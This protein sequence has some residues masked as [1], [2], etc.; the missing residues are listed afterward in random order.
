MLKNKSELEIAMYLAECIADWVFTARF[1]E[2][3]NDFSLYEDLNCFYSVAS[4][5]I[6]Q[7]PESKLAK[8]ISYKG[9]LYR[10]HLCDIDEDSYGMATSW[11]ENTDIIEEMEEDIM[12]AIILRDHVRPDTYG[13]SVYGLEQYLNSHG[14]SIRSY[15]SENKEPDVVNEQKIIIE[16]RE[17]IYPLCIG[18]EIFDSLKTL[19]KAGSK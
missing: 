6:N 2:L 10:F 7:Y 14:D 3:Q 9:I 15:V 18:V 12:G 8:Y 1:G 16:E 19:L 4:D 11:S 13:I 5:F 17:I